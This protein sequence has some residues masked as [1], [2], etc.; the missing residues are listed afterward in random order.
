MA[1]MK[2]L[3]C[4]LLLHHSGENQL[5]ITVIL[6][7]A[8]MLVIIISAIAIFMWIRK[9]HKKV[10]PKLL[11]LSRNL[12]DPGVI[13]YILN[14]GNFYPQKITIIWSC[15][16]EITQALTSTDSISE[17]PDK[18]YSVSS[19]VIIPEDRHKDPGFRVR[20][21]WEHESMEKPES[22][23]LSM[24]DS[25][26]RW[27][28]AVGDIQIPRLLLGS[29][30][31]LQC[32][33]SGYFPDAVTVKW[34][35]RNGDKLHEETDDNRRIT[36]R[37]APDN[38]YSRTASL[39]ITPDLR[40]HQGAEYICVV[41]H[42]SLETPI[43]RSTGI[44]QVFAKPKMSQ[45]MTRR[46]V[47]PKQM[48]YLLNLE[49]FYPKIIKIT[50]MCGEGRTEKLISST[51]SIKENP[52]RTYN[53]S[54]E[55][56]IPEDRHKDPGFRVRV[57]WEH[58]SMEE[59]ESRKLSIR[60]SGY[61]WKPVLEDI[62]VPRLLLGSPAVL[63]CN[64]SGYFPDAVTVKWMRR[65]GNKLHEETDDNQRITSR[66]AANNTYSRTASLTITPDLRTH[67]GAKY[68]CVVQHPSLETPIERST[69]RL[70]VCVK[71][72]M[73]QP[74]TRTIPVSGRMTYL[75]NLEKFYP[76]PI[77]IVWTCEKGRTKEAVSTRES[78]S[79][80]P[81]RTYNV[82]NEVVIP[83]DHHKVPGFR[84]RVTWEHESMEKPE[85]QELSLRDSDYT[86]TPVV[87]DIQVPRLLLGSPAALQCNISG[88]FPDAVTVKWMRRDG[89]K[90]HEDRITSRR[91]AD[92]TYSRTASLTITPDLWTHQGAEYICVV[93]HPSLE[94]PIERS[95][96]R[97][98]V[99]AKP[100]MLQSITRK[101]PTSGGMKYLINLEKFYPKPIKIDWKCGKGRTIEAISSTHS[102][103]ENPDRTYNVSSEVVIPE[104]RHK[105]PGFSVRVTWEH[106]SMEEPESRELSIRDSGTGT[107][108]RGQRNVTKQKP[109]FATQET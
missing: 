25:G 97:L 74:I 61:R 3:L 23:E 27:T 58:A 6:I 71:P 2:A 107:D 49:K 56:D 100:E 75:I 48:K 13:K 11:Q 108:G 55:I 67:E 7:V 104:D 12:L 93:Q 34:M 40:T 63:Q 85:S 69:R 28:P 33:I 66:R 72:K 70:R 37:R 47:I 24:R 54:S 14:L 109:T 50:W 19:E 20:V 52:D 18:T 57:T 41:E 59:P 10:K 39:T 90:L 89:D 1:A 95:T 91:A 64:I 83:E 84:V 21:T 88:Y 5:M 86:W 82:S 4:L 31:A 46:L 29:P 80:N 76:K 65:D 103:S 60:D 96:G 78:I 35:R 30:V 101:I 9:Y 98:R 53:V 16:P 32:N 79:E 43:E 38:T 17:N 68:I 73:L 36:S 42:P 92:N 99:W 87:E 22:Q 51:D 94:K 8:I 15:E 45:A 102:I 105:D 62:Q 77:K 81:D 44:M 106:E 26:Y